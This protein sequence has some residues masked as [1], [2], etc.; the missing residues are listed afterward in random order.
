SHY[1]DYTS[2]G[3][4]WDHYPTTRF[5]SEYGFQSFPSYQTLL[6]VF[7]EED[8]QIDSDMMEHRQHHPN[9]QAELDLQLSMHFDYDQNNVTF[10][11]YLY[12]TQLRVT[13]VNDS[14]EDLS[15]NEEQPKKIE[16]NLRK[17]SG[18]NSS[19]LFSF[20]LTSSVPSQSA[21][22]A[23]SVDL[24]NDLQFESICSPGSQSGDPY[25]N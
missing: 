4:S 9:G 25:Q 24:I 11:Y 16:I 3:W 6:P 19:N 23:V 17:F 2:N 13:I 7:S 18:E 20:E 8:M 5:A 1:Y 22:E 21:F 10:S 15:F 12:L 14:P